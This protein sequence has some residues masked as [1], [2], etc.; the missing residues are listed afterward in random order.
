MRFLIITYDE[1]INIPYI[2]KYEECIAGAGNEYDVLIWNRRCNIEKHSQNHFVFHLVT[3]RSKISKIIPFLKWRRFVLA[4][5][6]NM[7]YDR[8]IVLTTIPAVLISDLLFRKFKKN[9]FLDIRDY[10]YEEFFLYRRLVNE[11]VA[12]SALTSISSKAF[13]QFLKMH[14]NIIITH[15]LSNEDAVENHCQLSVLEQK[16]LVIGFVGGI[17][18]YNENIKLLEQLRN[19]KRFVLKYVGKV[20]PGCDLRSF[21][22]THKISNAVFFPE[23]DNDQKSNIYSSIDIINAVYGSRSPEVRLALP[24]KLYDCVLFKKPIMVSKGTYL[25]E[26]VNK[27]HLGLSIDVEGDNVGYCLNQYLKNFDKASFEKG[28]KEF[29]M[30]V[31]KEDALSKQQIYQFCRGEDRI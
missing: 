3:K 5:L 22:N 29:L 10:T 30:L 21:C 2:K 4:H 28:C 23:Y 17:R 14:A 31:Q 13:L 24:N 9:Y 27:Y 18:Y 25:A 19:S 1:Y 26:V 7:N 15:N 8:V 16:P 12:Q 11:L 20:H 6:S